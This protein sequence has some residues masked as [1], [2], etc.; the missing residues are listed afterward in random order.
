MELYITRDQILVFFFQTH[1]TINAFILLKLSNYT[2]FIIKTIKNKKVFI[3]F[4]VQSISLRLITGS[5]NDLLQTKIFIMTSNYPLSMNLQ[6]VIKYQRF[7]AKLINYSNPLVISTMP[8][9][10]LPGNV[11]RRLKQSG[12]DIC[13]MNFF[14]SAE[15]TPV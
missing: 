14:M 8:S 15:R 4:I 11:V 3:T 2:F 1:T 6:K 10:S 13:D 7:H 12:L 9:L 5:I